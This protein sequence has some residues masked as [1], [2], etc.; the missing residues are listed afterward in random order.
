[1]IESEKQARGLS[2]IDL[3][4]LPSS[5]RCLRRIFRPFLF[6]TFIGPGLVG[7]LIQLC[8]I[9][10]D[11]EEPGVIADL[12]TPGCSSAQERYLF[13]AVFLVS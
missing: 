3:L 4:L 8:T 11:A 10:I 12:V 13:G 2:L 5:R 1:V 6:V 9:N 7:L